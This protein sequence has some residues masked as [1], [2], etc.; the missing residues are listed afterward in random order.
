[1]SYD[2]ALKTTCAN[3]GGNDR[4]TYN[5]TFEPGSAI[6][7]VQ[8]FDW[9][10]YSIIDSIDGSIVVDP[11]VFEIVTDVE[12][13]AFVLTGKLCLLSCHVRF[14][15]NHALSEYTNVKVL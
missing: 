14:S 6:N 11:M 2:I 13:Y 1:M 5:W 4:V 7:T 12:D 10:A 9:D 8:T 3:C 15:R